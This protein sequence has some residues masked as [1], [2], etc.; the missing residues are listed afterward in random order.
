MG[1]KLQLPTRGLLVTACTS[2]GNIYSY[3]L[4]NKVWKPGERVNDADTVAKEGL[5]ALNGD[6]ENFF[7]VWLDIRNNNEKGQQ[8]FGAKSDDGGRSWQK[9]ILVYASPDELFVNAA[10]PPL[11]YKVTMYMLCFVTGLVVPGI[12]M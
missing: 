5:M 1:H 11:L 3:Y 7:A 10:N 12:C 2:Q 4:E 9:N 8:V 6:G